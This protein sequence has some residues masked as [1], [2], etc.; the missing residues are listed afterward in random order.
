[1]GQCSCTEESIGQ[2]QCEWVGD[3]PDPSRD[4]VSLRY[5]SNGDAASSFQCQGND[6]K[7]SFS[8]CFPTQLLTHR[9]A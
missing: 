6:V 2:T 4:D 7:K 9:S 5:R 1:M 8:C 3:A